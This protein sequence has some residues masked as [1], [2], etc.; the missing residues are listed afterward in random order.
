MVKTQHLTIQRV[1]WL[2]ML[3]AA[4]MGIGLLFWVLQSQP[5][6]SLIGGNVLNAEPY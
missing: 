2:S 5:R 4:G 6:T 1:S 3:F